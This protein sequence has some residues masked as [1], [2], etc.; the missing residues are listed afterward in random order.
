MLDPDENGTMVPHTRNA[1]VHQPPL[2]EHDRAHSK[3]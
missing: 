1:S 2:D 3:Q